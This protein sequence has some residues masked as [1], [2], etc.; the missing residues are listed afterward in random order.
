MLS[1]VFFTAT[2]NRLIGPLSCNVVFHV[3]I[4]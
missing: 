1:R 4:K 3:D 2:G